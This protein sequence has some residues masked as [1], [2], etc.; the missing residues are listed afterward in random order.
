MM[1]ALPIAVVTDPKVAA[2]LLAPEAV[3]V[4]STVD[5]PVPF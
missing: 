4:G 1:R 5:F 3:V 2:L